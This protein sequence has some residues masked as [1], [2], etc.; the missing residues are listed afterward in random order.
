MEGI[1]QLGQMGGI[2]PPVS[3]HPSI[4]LLY[5]TVEITMVYHEKKKA[6]VGREPCR[7]LGER[8]I[9]LRQSGRQPHVALPVPIK[10]GR[11]CDKPTAVG[12][13]HV[14]TWL[15]AVTYQQGD[16]LF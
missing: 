13:E 7:Q 4:R 15:A 6:V 12:K 9:H 1:E 8:G 3:P 2:E 5:A 16:V 11:R 14:A 10:V